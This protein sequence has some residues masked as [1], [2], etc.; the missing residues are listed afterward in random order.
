MAK[1]LDELVERLEYMKGVRYND[2]QTWQE[3]SDLMMP[4][5]GDITT[6][7][8]SGSRRIPPVFDSTA[9][10]AADTFV[11]FIK[12]A[13]IPGNLDWLKLEA[14]APFTDDLK[15]QEA[16]DLT[17]TK[18]LE[19]LSGSNF[20]M[21]ATAFLRD[22]AVL[23]NGT[24]YVN[25]R[26]PKLNRSGSTFGGVSFEAVPVRRM[27]W[28]NGAEQRPTIMAR[29][30]ELP[31]LDAYKFFDGK[32]GSA[33][34]EMLQRDRMGK[35]EYYHFVYENEDDVPGGI[36]TGEERPWVSQFLSLS[37]RPEMI[38]TSG[39]EFAP[40]IISRWMVVDGETYGRGRGHLARPDTKGV[41]E[42]RRQ[43]LIAAGKD[44]S[45]PLM[46]EHDT[47]VTLDISPNGIMVTRP[48]MK[49][50]P[51]YLKSDARYEV[52]DGI[53]RLDREQIGRAFMSEVFDEPET[54]PRSAEES[55]LR[56]Q[57]ML[58]KMASPAEVMSH[59]FLTPLIDAVVELMS[60]NG[61]LPE[62]QAVTEGG[63]D[64]NI[65]YQSP[66]FTAQKASGG[67]KVQAFLERR[68]MLFQATQDPAWLDDI[69]YDAI[70]A[71]DART[72]DVPA[73]I[74]RTQEEVAMRRE[75]RA[76]AQAQQMMMEQAQ[77]AAQI[78]ASQAGG[79]GGAPQ[80]PAIPGMTE[81]P[82]IG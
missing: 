49:M 56:Q 72:A 21:Q 42:L 81:G 51:T 55:R 68:L 48:P 37:G 43:I 23:G 73:E 52:A 16:L 46:V 32:P 74:F 69:D 15:V 47:M 7:K 9:M 8:T 33:C 5:R 3:I 75:A 36:A 29:V 66:V 24:M 62:L 53:A 17:S 44:L 18:I 22:F 31:A 30:F 57:R 79:P 40:Y 45:P 63:V 14:S 25:E 26:P 67:A 78:A 13:V 11:N 19:A 35:V 10:Q 6:T 50:N 71:Y 61:A 77:Q 1:Q 28:S 4:F 80:E 65:Q 64:V 27:W 58:Q 70:T 82:P 2:E 38:R 41:N 54:Q 39:Y 12:G 76:Q 34:L 60:R 59:E 20:Y